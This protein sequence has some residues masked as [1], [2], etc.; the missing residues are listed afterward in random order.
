MPAW[1]RLATH[2]CSILTPD[3]EHVLRTPDVSLGVPQRQEGTGD[4]FPLLFFCLVV[5]EVNT[6][7]GTIVFTRGV[8]GRRIKTTEIFGQGLRRMGFWGT[9]ERVAQ[10][11][12]A[13]SP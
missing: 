10:I 3:L 2:V 11:A 6:R 7:S 12:F 4:F 9:T 13:C 1:Q 5:H 8:N